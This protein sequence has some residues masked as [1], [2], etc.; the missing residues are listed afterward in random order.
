MIYDLIPTIKPQWVDE[1]TVRQVTN[2]V[3]RVLTESDHVL[4]I[5]NFSRSEIEAYCIES[6][7]QVQP[8]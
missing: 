1:P 8:L 3:R 5:S 7:F 2:W 4:T 6:R